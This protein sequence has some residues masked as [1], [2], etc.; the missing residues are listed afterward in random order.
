[1]KHRLV[2]HKR[3]GTRI[4]SE[5]V[6]ARDFTLLRLLFESFLWHSKGSVDTVST[7]FPAKRLWTMVI[8]SKKMSD[9]KCP[10]VHNHNPHLNARLIDTTKLCNILKAFWSRHYGDSLVST[11]S[12]GTKFHIWKEISLLVL[13]A[14]YFCLQARLQQEN[15]LLVPISNRALPTYV[16]STHK[17][18]FILFTPTQHYCSL[19]R[20]D[21]R[22]RIPT[23]TTPS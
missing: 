16:C 21:I 23:P 10:L 1:M 15:G 13:G 12:T 4:T 2:V 17:Y 9:H 3:L 6:L 11:Q 7:L 8:Q 5:N 22:R 20:G 18:C 19:I 14:W